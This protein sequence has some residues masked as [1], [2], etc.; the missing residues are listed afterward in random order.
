M[1]KFSRE[2]KLI[3]LS[4]FAD[5]TSFD[6]EERVLFF[7]SGTRM[8]FPQVVDREAEKIQQEKESTIEYAT[9]KRSD[10]R[11]KTV[12]TIDGADAKDLDDAI[13]IEI[14]KDGNYL[15]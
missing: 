8:D 15:L 11:G 5:G 14:D 4:K 13:S 6:I 12:F 7:L 2:G 3:I 9:R 10:F 1:V